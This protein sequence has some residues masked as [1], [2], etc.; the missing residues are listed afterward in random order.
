MAKKKKATAK[1]TYSAVSAATFIGKSR[2][3][4]SEEKAMRNNETRE[5]FDLRTEEDQAVLARGLER[6]I[7]DRLHLPSH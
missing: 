5:F 7:A 6:L 4:S 3:V 1:R 2:A